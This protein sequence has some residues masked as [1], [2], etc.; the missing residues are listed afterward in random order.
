MF[1]WSTQ[2]WLQGDL[3]F[4]S[5]TSLIPCRISTASYPGHLFSNYKAVY[6]QPGYIT[7]SAYKTYDIVLSVA[8]A[9]W[10]YLHW[11][12]DNTLTHQ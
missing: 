1:D 12:H 7:S 4:T 5:Y 2:D 11:G 8:M 3:H 9:T 10:S 6:L